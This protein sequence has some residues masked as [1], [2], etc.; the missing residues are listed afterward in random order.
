MV[1]NQSVTRGTQNA[2]MCDGQITHFIFCTEDSG[3]HDLVKDG[4]KK[5]EGAIRKR[6]ILIKYSQFC[7][8]NNY[9]DPNVVRHHELPFVLV[10]Y[11]Q[12]ISASIDISLQI[13]EKPELL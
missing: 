7:I 9:P 3:A 12:S 11:M 2:C 13:N 5:P 8:A 4:Q 6:Y 10:A 1:H